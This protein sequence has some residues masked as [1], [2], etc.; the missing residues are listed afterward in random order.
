MKETVKEEIEALL[1]KQKKYRD[2]DYSQAQL[3]TDLGVSTFALSRILKQE[4]GMTYT[5]LVH[6][7]RIR[8]AIRQLATPRLQHYT[9]DNIALLTGFGN[10]QSF[11][12]A[13]KKETGTTPE[14]YREC[15]AQEKTQNKS[16]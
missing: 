6:K 5:A 11:Y 15:V 3:A 9:I 8:D 4:F 7:H 14:K 2:C 12:T 16:I 1:I 13:F 10:R